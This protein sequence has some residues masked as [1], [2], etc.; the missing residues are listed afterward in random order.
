[1]EQQQLYHPTRVGSTAV[2]AS[3]DDAGIVEDQQVAGTQVVRDLGKP[4]PVGD[5]PRRPVQHQ[6]P[7]GVAGLH[8]RLR[9]EL[10]GE[11][12]VEVV[13]AISL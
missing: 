7:R 3:L 10:L 2:H 4:L 12:V 1:M 13:S 11:R 9:N 6:Q 8:R 5:R